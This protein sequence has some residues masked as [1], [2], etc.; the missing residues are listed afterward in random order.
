MCAET[1]LN[2]LCGLF[3]VQAGM[4]GWHPHQY[5][6]TGNPPEKGDN[7]AAV[8]CKRINIGCVSAPI[9]FLLDVWLRWCLCY[10]EPE[11]KIHLFC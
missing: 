9:N 11:A 2:S 4:C 5:C 7:L 1:L 8:L 6:G 3:L 10:Q